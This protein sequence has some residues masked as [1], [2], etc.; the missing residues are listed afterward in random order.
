MGH[1]VVLKAADGFESQA[2][3]AQPAIKP[4]GAIV[5]LQEIFGVNA[6]VRAVAD[7]YALAGYLAIAPATF[8]ASKPASSWATRRKT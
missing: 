4:R 2:Y 1:L 3:V 6:H 5:V 8:T 7:G